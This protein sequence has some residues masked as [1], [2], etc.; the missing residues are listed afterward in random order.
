M[1]S[2]TIDLTGDSDV[3]D[4][5]IS[6]IDH[7]TTLRADILRESLNRSQTKSPVKPGPVSPPVPHPSQEHPPFLDMIRSQRG[8]PMSSQLSKD[9]EDQG[10]EVSKIEDD[11]VSTKTQE[12]TNTDAEV[13]FLPI[14][15]SL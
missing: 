10:G 7:T 14:L 11:I 1:A 12:S 9:T 3:D 15:V 13:S 8:F 5:H 2:N 6:E 4:G